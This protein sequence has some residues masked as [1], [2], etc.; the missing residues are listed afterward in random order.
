MEF[1][2][3][4]AL[5]IF[6]MATPPPFCLSADR[7]WVHNRAI[8]HPPSYLGTFILI[9]IKLCLMNWVPLLRKWCRKVL[10]WAREHSSNCASF[11]ACKVRCNLILETVFCCWGK[12]LRGSL[13]AWC[14]QER[15]T[16]AAPHLVAGTEIK[17]HVETPWFTCRKDPLNTKNLH[18]K[19]YCPFGG[20]FNRYAQK[21]GTETASEGMGR[22][23]L[24]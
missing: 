17:L 7:M 5:A 6:S 15:P 13:T 23:R 24:L 9:V 8:M 20:L 16:S 22:A 19:E 2:F 4:E 3:V 18:K 10:L 14:F 1:P 12:Y 21:E 11:S